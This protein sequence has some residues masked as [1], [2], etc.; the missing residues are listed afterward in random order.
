VDE[1]IVVATGSILKNITIKVKQLA[2]NLV[3]AIETAIGK[4]AKK[5]DMK[6]SGENMEGE[7]L[8]RLFKTE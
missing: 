5:V 4:T 3:N 6:H 2:K 8:K 7:R 1:L